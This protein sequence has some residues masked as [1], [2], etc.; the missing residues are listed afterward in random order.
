ML[1]GTGGD[2]GQE[3]GVLRGT[4][5]SGG[6][7][8]VGIDGHQGHGRVMG[9]KEG[10]ALLGGMTAYRGAIAGGDCRAPDRKSVV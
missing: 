10:W 4:G 5:G 2:Q 7:L 8:L 3:L 1:G 9:G 6:W